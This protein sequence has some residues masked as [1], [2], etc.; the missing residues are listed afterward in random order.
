MSL[1]Q[2]STAVATIAGQ[3]L[4][5]FL[6]PLGAPAIFLIDGLTY[7][8]TS[9]TESRVVMAPRKTLTQEGKGFNSV[10][11][12]TR[13][14][15]DYVWARPALR[16]LFFSA[17]PLNVLAAPIFVL[18]P[19]YTTDV[20]H[21]E[22]KWYGYLM[23]A[24]SFGSL[25]GYLLAGLSY[26]LKT[27]LFRVVAGCVFLT[28]LVFGLLGW[29]T[30]PFSALV[31]MA[32]LGC[33]MGWV[34][35]TTATILQQGTEPLARGRV[36]GLLIS[37]TQGLTPIAML[38]TGYAAHLTRN[39]VPLIYSIAGASSLLVG[40]GLARSSNVRDFFESTLASVSEDEAVI[41]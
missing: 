8:F 39:N 5:G 18:L 33:M 15:F 10:W 24:I 20:L 34:S 40:L 11:S 37:I 38:V 41:T 12:D 30:N 1:S 7:L 19:F 6:V 16:E 32:L 13:N 14:G 28:S 22:A 35:M 17:V 29:I 2:S 9:V 27:R 26:K 25:S 4:G 3:V 36:F 31:M 21:R 23:A